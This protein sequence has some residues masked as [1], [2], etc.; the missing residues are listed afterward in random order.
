MYCLL[1]LTSPCDQFYANQ[2]AGRE[3]ALT[4]RVEMDLNRC[5]SPHQACLARRPLIARD[6][7][8]DAPWMLILHF[9]LSTLLPNYWT[10]SIHI[11]HIM[12]SKYSSAYFD[13][14]FLRLFI[15]S[16]IILQNKLLSICACFCY[17]CGVFWQPC[18]H[19]KHLNVSVP[20]QCFTID[21][22]W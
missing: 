17:L 16:L 22:L 15:D 12:S 8:R 18:L 14:D 2:V 1:P 21:S 11:P 9:T 6:A 13:Y 5:H 10:M 19:L 3:A 20:A 7:W 4:W